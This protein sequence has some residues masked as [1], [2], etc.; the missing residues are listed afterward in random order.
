M[1][2]TIRHDLLILGSGLAGLRA[3]LEASIVTQGRLNIGLISK[4]QL[5][6]SHS[7]AA[8]GGTAAVL[9]P[10]E[11]DSL[12][13]HAWDTVKG[14]DF[15]ADQDAVFRFVEMMPAEIQLL[16]K[17]GIPWSRRPDGR[18]AQRP[19][20]GHSFNRAVYA[21]DKTGFFE[22]QT[23]YDT[24]LKY[25][26]FSRYDET[27]VTSIQTADG[28][29]AGLTAIDMTTGELLAF[30]GKAL[31]IATGGTGR[32]FGFTTYAHTVTGDGMALAFKAGLPLKDME[33]LQFHPTGLIPSGILM[34]E[35][36][37]GEG[38]YLVNSEGERFLKRYAP[39][40]MEL[41]PRDLVSRSI[42]KELEA[43]KGYQGPR[44]LDYI[45]LDLRHLGAE[46][47]KDRLPLIREICMKFIGVDPTDA[48]IPIRPVAHYSMGGIHT[49]I[50]GATPTP[51]IWSA[52]EAAC[53]S[54]HGANR[55]G[56]NS[57]AECL[58]WG[59][60]TGAL[61]AAYCAREAAFAELS[62]ARV[63]EEE[64]RVFVDL[65]GR[66][67]EENMYAIRDDLRNLMD[68]NM[69]VFRT[70][71]SIQKAKDGIA[72]LKARFARSGIADKQ[73]VYNTDLLTAL[74]ME[75]LL[76]C[77]EAA[78]HGALARR[79]SRGGHARRDF[80]TRDDENFLKHT[81]VYQDGDGMRL[82]YIP[83]T[84]THWKPVERKY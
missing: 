51:G 60:I 25:N 46:R 71:E 11:G 27:F 77:A 6:R 41:A 10:E 82:D 17:W 37:R 38:G 32:M 67:G 31:I 64:K 43:G 45:H 58:V 49:D 44:G 30:Q 81:M 26:N 40:K 80:A 7:V 74:E 42:I 52:G 36:C 24:L 23:L 29:F 12:E 50:D 53:V 4:V 14:S 78:V 8:E 35:A 22:M 9:R 56:S 48:P 20:G 66:G 18:I 68:L 3:A 73:R 83:V 62:Q 72:E 57:T 63:A 16:D 2:R 33:F 75:Y 84:I 15:L 13:L 79:E 21:A 61:A 19:F 76:I 69:G 39:E 34:T 28:R 59:K 47:I 55:L 70:G 5:M 1:A 65:L 54:M